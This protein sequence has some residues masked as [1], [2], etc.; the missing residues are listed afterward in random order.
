MVTERQE[1]ILNNLIADYIRLARPIS[2]K[3]LEKKHNFGLSPATIRN[4][5]QELTK[6]GYIAQPHTSAGRVPTD[7]G[8]RFFVNNFLEELDEFF[9]KEFSKEMREMEKE[10]RDSLKF[11]RAVTK[12]L[13]SVSSNL[14][15]SYNFDEKVFW[16][17]GW[18]ETLAEPEFEDIDIVSEFT[19]MVENLEKNIKDFCRGDFGEIKINIGK[20]NPR[21]LKTKK[22]TII[23]STYHFP[24]KKKGMI[25]ILGPTRMEYPK[26]ISLINSVLKTLSKY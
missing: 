8:Y 13:A 5:M 10:L 7:K 20:E 4:E 9:E 25:A 6:K 16:K 2:S 24:K 21:F 12:I 1:K 19:E 23:R 17:E 18:R 26:N 15:L 22:F 3:F 14:A 11:H